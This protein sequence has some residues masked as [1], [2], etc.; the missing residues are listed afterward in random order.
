MKLCCCQMRDQ[1][2]GRKEG[3]ERAD[4][5]A[6]LLNSTLMPSRPE[7]S[8]CRAASTQRSRFQRS[9]GWAQLLTR[10]RQAGRAGVKSSPGNRPPEQKSNQNPEALRGG[11]HKAQATRSHWTCEEA[12]QWGYSHR[13]CTQNERQEGGCAYQKRPTTHMEEATEGMSG[14]YQGP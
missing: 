3:T 5:K 1:T 14:G 9:Q 6:P 12:G 4:P 11:L 13:M 10:G 8:P 2:E 7:L